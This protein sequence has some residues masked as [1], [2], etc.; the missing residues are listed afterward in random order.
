LRWRSTLFIRAQISKAN[1]Q[2]QT[3]IH[4]PDRANLVNVILEK[5]LRVNYTQRYQTCDDLL[6]AL[7]NP[8]NDPDQLLLELQGLKLTKTVKQMP[9][10]LSLG[11]DWVQ[12]E[13]EILA[14]RMDWRKIGYWKISNVDGSATDLRITYHIDP[15]D[16][17]FKIHLEVAVSSAKTF[18]FICLGNSETWCRDQ[19]EVRSG[20]LPLVVCFLKSL[21]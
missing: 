19:M 1:T 2:E 15:V 12:K 11:V 20:L 3:R 21:Q 4:S 17:E 16:C 14:E 10:L 6:V 18:I 5:G 7:S 13:M 8:P 9:S